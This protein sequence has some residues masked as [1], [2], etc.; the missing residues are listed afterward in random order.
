[1]LL[2]AYKTVKELKC[3]DWRSSSSRKSIIDRCANF[4]RAEL[5]LL[6]IFQVQHACDAGL[7]AVQRTCFMSG[8]AVVLR[9]WPA[10]TVVHL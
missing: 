1:L 3:G 9:P 10:N 5:M 6:V 7:H 2:P 4:S 8:Q